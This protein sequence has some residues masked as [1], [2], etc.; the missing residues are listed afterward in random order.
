MKKS[1]I[2]AGAASV[3]LA[4]MPMVGAFALTTQ[5]DTLQVTIN[6]V[7]SFGYTD[8]QSTHVIDV[9]APSH[10]DG[11]AGAGP[12]TWNNDTLSATMLNGTENQDFGKTTLNVYCNNSD[13]Y[14]ITTNGTTG[15]VTTVGALT[16]NDTSDTIPVNAGFSASSTG[17]S[18]QVAG[19]TGN[20]GIVAS[21]HDGTWATAANAEDT[22][23]EA[24]TTGAKTTDNSGDTF[25]IT[26][27]VGIDETLSAGTYSGSITYTLV[28]L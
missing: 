10:T 5:T 24:P 22:I 13:G 1:I 12:A 21:A 28:Q 2:A 23:V 18:Y 14:Q 3:A 20:T 9:A 15:A 7:C 11:T 19:T 4:A 25:T 17:W 26:Y 16:S 8:S 27:G 6:G